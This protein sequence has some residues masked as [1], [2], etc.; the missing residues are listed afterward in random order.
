MSWWGRVLRQAPIALLSPA[1]IALEL[2]AL[3]LT[4]L[5]WSLAGNRKWPPDTQPRGNSASVVI[6][7]WNGRDLLEKYLPG[8]VEA[9]S[10]HPDNEVIVVDNGS[11]DGSAAFLR[12]RFPQVR[13][14]ALEQNLGFGGGSNR[15]FREAKNDIVVLLNSDMRVARD[16]LPPLLAGFSAPDVFAVSCQIFFSDPAKLREETGL[17]QASW[18]RGVIELRHRIDDEVRGAFPCFYGGGGSCAFDRRKFF[19]LGGFDELLRPFYLEDT[20][21]GYLAWKRG[22]RV[23]YQPKSHV[24]HEHRGTIGRKFSQHYIQAVIRKNLVL[25]AW[26]NLHNPRMLA[27]NFF[28][29]HV[30]ALVALISG[31]APGRANFPGLWRAFWQL[32]Q[33]CAARWRARNLAAIS[34]REAF[35]RPLGGYYRD[36]FES[37]TVRTKRPRVLFVSPYGLAPASHGGAVFMQFAVRELS[38]HCEVHLVALLDEEWERAAHEVLRPFLAS[39]QFMVRMP[40]QPRASFTLIP[41]AVSEYANSDFEW[42][43]HRTMATRQIDVLQIEYT[44]LGQFGCEFSHMLSALFEHDV[45]FQSIGRQLRSNPGWLFRIPA[46]IEYLRALRW[47]IKMLPRFDQ[48][49]VCTTANRDYLLSL[50][51]TLASKLHAGQ[52]A[53]IEVEEFTPN[54]TPRTGNTI[55]FV[56]GFRHS[57]NLEALQWFFAEVVPL[58]QSRGVDF[59][60]RAIGVDPPPAYAFANSNGI[61]ELAGYRE[62]IAEDL[63]QAPVFICPILAGSGVRV[64]LLEAFAYGIPVVSTPIGAEGLAASDGE[65]CRLAATPAD[66][67]RA[68]EDLLG[69]RAAA[70][71][72]GAR[73]RDYVLRDWDARVVIARLAAAYSAGLQSKAASTSS[74]R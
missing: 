57:P 54:L 33:A 35:R 52:R 70:A 25:F 28:A 11:T 8:V 9:M 10:G 63:R 56:G 5:L 21:L 40:G 53:G 44:S 34:D 41:G 23:L 66:F 73:A 29:N 37:A 4:D 50:E 59:Q 31:D 19:E 62:S 14:I 2:A 47:E 46:A 67:A 7:N 22:W 49:Q 39:M 45:Y 60:V 6:P 74:S 68:I 1:L 51:P 71:A 20:D 48:I 24:W 72:M 43:L 18:R 61:L 65:V 12:E 42:L 69:D 13:L 17:T 64:K 36:R 58:L 38:R 30:Q 27:E 55:L 26:K 16:F 32:P 15:G 3:C